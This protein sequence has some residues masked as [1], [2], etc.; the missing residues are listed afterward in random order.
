MAST[1]KE[2]AANNAGLVAPEELEKDA[3]RKAY[4][5][6]YSKANTEGF[7]RKGFADAVIGAFKSVPKSVVLQWCYCLEAHTNSAKHFHKHKLSKIEVADIIIE[8]KIENRLELLRLATQCRKSG[9]SDLYL[10]CIERSSKMLVDFIGTDW[11]AENAEKV[12][13][14]RK[15]SRMEILNQ[16]LATTC[17]C[18]GQW[19]KCALE[20]LEKNRIERKEFSCAIMDLLE[21]WRGKGRNVCLLALQIV[22]RHFCLTH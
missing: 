13:E 11:D 6:M 19:V 9:A 17:T 20:L 10:F 3:R 8:D 7:D 2:Q 18:E 5:I 21:K 15:L 16:S 4:L 12:I 1:D 14:R 22:G